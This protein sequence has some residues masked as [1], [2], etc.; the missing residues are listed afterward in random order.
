[1]QPPDLEG[2]FLTYSHPVPKGLLVFQLGTLKNDVGNE[3]RV[4]EL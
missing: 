4:V 2:D 1:M 3:F